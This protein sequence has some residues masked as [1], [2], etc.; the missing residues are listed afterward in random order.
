M[1]MVFHRMIDLGEINP[2]LPK[3]VYYADN[4]KRFVR[5]IFYDF[6]SLYPYVFGKNLPVG[7]GFLFEKNSKGTFSIKSLH[8]S[9][10]KSSFRAIEWL[11]YLTFRKGFGAQIRHA[12]NSGEVKVA[13]HF[14]V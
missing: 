12:G 7:P 8:Q 4:G 9:G 3:A 14:I 13:G 2:L 10:K 11:E 6:N 5:L 1:T